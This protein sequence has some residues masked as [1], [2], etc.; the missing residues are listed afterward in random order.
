M[1]KA[2]LKLSLSSFSQ[3]PYGGLEQYRDGQNLVS[4]DIEQ[5]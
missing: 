4:V 3:K 1:Q 5:K 2:N